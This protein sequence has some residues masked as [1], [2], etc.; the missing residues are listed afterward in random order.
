MGCNICTWNIV[1]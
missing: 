1:F